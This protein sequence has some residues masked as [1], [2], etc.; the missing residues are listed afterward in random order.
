[1]VGCLILLD[2][3]TKE[4]GEIIMLI[5]RRAWTL[6]NN[7]THAFRP[8]G[9][10]DFVYFLLTFHESLLQVQQQGANAGEKGKRK[11]WEAAPI[12]G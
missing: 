10:S 9:I 1:M 8:I 11:C 2:R 5:F 3:C 12:T 4:H 6:H 7:M